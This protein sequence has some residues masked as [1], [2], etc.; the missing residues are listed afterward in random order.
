MERDDD[1]FAAG[2]EAA[3]AD[4]ATGRLVYRCRGHAGHWGHWIVTQLRERFGVEVNEGF[5]VC[6]V[7][8]ASKSFDDAYN[9]VLAEEINRRHGPRAFEAVFAESREQSEEALWA[10][11]QTWLERHPNS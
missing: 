1:A 10:A 9:K 3:R 11:K 4:I 8:A 5:G 2:V 7:D 6:L